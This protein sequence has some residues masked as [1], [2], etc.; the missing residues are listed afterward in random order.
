[1]FIERMNEENDARFF[2]T[3]QATLLEGMTSDSW[4]SFNES[5]V[6]CTFNTYSEHQQ[7]F[8]QCL[9]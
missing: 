6:E 5:V 1:M 8:P 2:I 4:Q 9:A 3:P 7:N